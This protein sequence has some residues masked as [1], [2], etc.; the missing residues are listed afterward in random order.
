M[1]GL[2]SSFLVLIATSNA[3][4]CSAHTC[5]NFQCWLY[6]CDELRRAHIGVDR[7]SSYMPRN[8][9][10]TLISCLTETSFTAVLIVLCPCKSNLGL[11]WKVQE[12]EQEKTKHKTA[13]ESARSAMQRSR[14]ESFLPRFWSVLPFLWSFLPFLWSFLPGKRR[15]RRYGRRR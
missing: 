7:V 8:E 5:Y 6:H 9:V 10:L 1:F 11:D 15:S 4:T 14:R 3:C 2:D 12:A 13:A